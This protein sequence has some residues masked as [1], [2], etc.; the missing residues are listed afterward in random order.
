MTENIL[1]RSMAVVQT[2]MTKEHIAAR[3]VLSYITDARSNPA[4]RMKATMNALASL[5]EAAQARVLASVE[6][7]SGTPLPVAEDADCSDEDD[8]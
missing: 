4:S 2:A 6:T 3:K 7:L 5:D 8:T 1:E